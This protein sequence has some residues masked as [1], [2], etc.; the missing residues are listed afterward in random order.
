MRGLQERGTVAPLSESAPEAP[1]RASAGRCLVVALVVAALVV[2]AD[3][4]TTS[5]A[6]AHLRGPVHLLGPFGLD[7]GYNTGSAFSLFTGAPAVLAV[8]AVVAV[9]GLVWA[10]RR[11]GRLSVAVALGLILG[12]ALGNLGD[13]LFRGHHGAVVDFVTL[14]HWPTF[15]VAD[16]CITVGTVLL[17]VLLWRAGAH[18]SPA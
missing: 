5:V 17:V 16:A 1:A 11:A 6:E 8:V 2:V 10:A 9:V 7:L 4:V 18:R 14:T 3:Q 12:G 13:R 15:N